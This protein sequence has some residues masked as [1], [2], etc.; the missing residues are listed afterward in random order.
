VAVTGFSAEAGQGLG[1]G[2][3]P[4]YGTAHPTIFWKAGAAIEPPY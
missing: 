3:I 4:K 2:L 1:H